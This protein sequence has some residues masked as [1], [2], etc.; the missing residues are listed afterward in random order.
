MYKDSAFINR[1]FV[2]SAEVPASIN[3]L[4]VVKV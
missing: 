1:M 2:A 4:P 3:K